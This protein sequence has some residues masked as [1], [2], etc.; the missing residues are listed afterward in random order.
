M[1]G[2]IWGGKV[3]S[4]NLVVSLEHK[5]RS[6][7]RAEERDWALRDFPDWGWGWSWYGNP[8]AFIIPDG[9]VNR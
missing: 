8:G 6:N 2:G 9:L 3:G 5:R 4:S 1:L 7:L